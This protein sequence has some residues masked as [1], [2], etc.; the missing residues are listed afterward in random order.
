[1]P[2]FFAGR[3]VSLMFGV[4]ALA[5][6]Y[7]LSRLFLAWPIAMLITALVGLNP[8]F[9]F[10]ATSFSNDMMVVAACHV[11]LWQL[12]R[13]AQSGLSLRQS[14]IFGI[15]IALATLT[16]LSGL[17]LLIPLGVLALWQSW[18]TRS[19]RPLCWA[20]VTGLIVLM[21]DGWWFLRNWNLYGNPFANFCCEFDSV[22]KAGFRRYYRPGR[23]Q[24]GR[25]LWMTKPWQSKSLFWQMS[26]IA[27]KEPQWSH[28]GQ[29][30]NLNARTP[31]S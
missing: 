19:A 5:A 14:I 26:G 23:E 4:V 7:L 27:S 3:L 10:I 13:M 6:I 15:T 12:G 18:K 28:P 21:V 8:Q 11:G 25:A 24:I 20:G 30:R 9:V 16:K 17:G 31:K 2:V 1:M 29:A 22:D